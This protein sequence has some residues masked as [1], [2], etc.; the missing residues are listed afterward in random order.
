MSCPNGKSSSRSTAIAL[1]SSAWS[2]SSRTACRMHTWHPRRSL[3]VPH[4]MLG[5]IRHI[6]VLT[7]LGSWDASQ[8]PL[9][10]HSGGNFENGKIVTQV[11]SWWHPCHGLS[12]LRR[13]GIHGYDGVSSKVNAFVACS[14][15]SIQH[16]QR[17]QGGHTSGTSSSGMRSESRGSESLALGFHCEA[18]NQKICQT[19]TFHLFR[20]LLVFLTKLLNVSGKGNNESHGDLLSSR[21]TA[22]QKAVTTNTN[23]ERHKLWLTM[24]PFCWIASQLISPVCN[25]NAFSTHPQSCFIENTKLSSSC[26]REHAYHTHAH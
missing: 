10:H 5:D 6:N 13:M 22:A 18:R 11:G 3:H 19:C 9:P 16:S 2:C 26:K 23:L 24:N 14:W 25:V 20:R 15:D 8:S 21:L 12:Q 17:I 7:V 1:S 4:A